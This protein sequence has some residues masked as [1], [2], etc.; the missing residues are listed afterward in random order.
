MVPAAG[1]CRGRG[2]GLALRRTCLGHRDGVVPGGS[3]Q[4]PSWAACAA[5]V[6]HVDPVTHASRFPYRM[7][8]DAGLGRCT[9][10][11]L[12]GCRHLPFR[13]GVCYARVPC[14]CPCACSSW[15]GRAGWPPGRV[16]VHLTFPVAVVR[17]CFVSSALSRLRLPC[18]CLFVSAFRSLF[19]IFSAAVVLAFRA[20]LCLG[21]CVSSHPPLRLCCFSLFFPLAGPLLFFLP[22]RL[23]PCSRFVPLLRAPPPPRS[24]VV[25]CFFASSRFLGRLFQFRLGGVPC[26]PTLRCCVPCCSFWLRVLPCCVPPCGGGGAAPP[27]P[28]L[29]A[30]WWFVVFFM[31][32][33]PFFFR[34]P[35]YCRVV[36]SPV[37]WSA[38]WCVCCRAVPSCRACVVLF[39][40]MVCCVVWLLAIL[41]CCLLRYLFSPYIGSYNDPL[42]AIC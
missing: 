3:L 2:A 31:P 36:H 8:F 11:V 39:G 15:P 7:S 21:P 26:L 30:P 37:V 38:L 24:F 23:S 42:G 40:A 4:R 25:F 20:L 18:P 22:V 41:R 14:A 10:A 9:G 35:V 5:V 19:C 28:P 13:V 6:W 17:A 34:L 29:P 12:C 16:L 33:A 27:P 1:P 32:A